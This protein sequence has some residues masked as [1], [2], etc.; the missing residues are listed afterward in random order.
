M[1]ECAHP[2]QIFG[3]LSPSDAGWLRIY[4][5]EQIARSREQMSDDIAR[6]LQV[7]SPTSILAQ[8]CDTDS[9]AVLQHV[10]PERNARDFRVIVVR[11]AQWHR[12][13][14]T[15]TAQITLWDAMRMVFSEGGTPG[16]IREGQRFQV[17][18]L[19]PSQPRAW[20]RPG[21]ESVIYLVS[22]KN[23]RWTNIKS[24]KQ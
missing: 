12:K 11:D 20:M 10:C 6:E 16:D 5:L 3:R 8:V 13:E 22:K 2:S 1:E 17:T 15:R 9:R 18:N 14:P 7:S 24:R 23:T 4:A 19:Q 21:P